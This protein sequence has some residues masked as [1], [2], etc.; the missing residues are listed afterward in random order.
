M[1]GL[2]GNAA[3]IGQFLANAPVTGLP[4]A[5]S[6]AASNCL[7]DWLGVTIAGAA[8]PVAQ[9]AVAYTEAQTLVLPWIAAGP[10]A[11]NAAFVNGAAAHALDFDDT[12]IPTDSHLSAVTWAALLALAEPGGTVARICFRPL[13][14]ATKWRRSWRDGG[15]GSLCSFGG[16]IQP[17]CWAG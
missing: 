13:L 2:K 10:A 4:P 17:L 1:S 15:W 8:E 6:H 11:E 9:A 3:A 5:V 12:H 14:L 16:S 7:I